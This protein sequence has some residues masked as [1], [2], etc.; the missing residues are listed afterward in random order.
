MSYKIRKTQ[1]SPTHFICEFINEPSSYFIKFSNSE[2]N[3]SELNELLKID[4]NTLE[5]NK[6]TDLPNE[7]LGT[8]L[9]KLLDQVINCVNQKPIELSRE[10]SSSIVKNP[11]L[12]SYRHLTA[13]QDYWKGYTPYALFK[14]LSEDL[15]EIPYVDNPAD[16]TERF[17]KKAYHTNHGST[18][19]IRQYIL[20]KNYLDF[21]K[22]EAKPEIKDIANQLSLEE[23]SCL[24]LA[25]FL[26]RSG[27][28]NEMGWVDD[29]TY[30]LRSAEIFSQIASDLGYN[31]KLIKLI[32]NSYDY[33]SKLLINESLTAQSLET[34]TKKAN[35]FRVL[36]KLAHETDLVRCEA[37]SE[38]LIEQIH[39]TLLEV[40]PEKTTSEASKAFLN[41][42]CVLCRETGA[43][44]TSPSHQLEK[45]DA[46]GNETKE[47]NSTHN[48]VA[49]CRRLNALKPKVFVPSSPTKRWYESAEHT[50]QEN[51][52]TK[53]WAHDLNGL[54]YFADLEWTN[55]Q[56]NTVPTAACVKNE[57][58]NNADFVTV[59]HATTKAS[60]A[61]E[62][63][64]KSLA[65]PGDEQITWHRISPTNKTVVTITDIE[66][67][68]ARSLTEVDNSRS[69][70][71]HLL[72]CNPTLWHN[73]DYDSQ[74]STVDYF[75]TD[76]SVTKL[77]FS[78]LI[79]ELLD[80][81]G[82]LIGQDQKRA[83]LVKAFNEL[84]NDK[85]FGSHGVI[86]QYHIPYHLVDEVAYIS[87]QNGKLD[88]ENPG[89]LDTLHSL[90]IS[91]VNIPNQ[92]TMQ[93]RL[94]VPKLMEIDVANQLKVNI[95]SGM[96]EVLEQEFTQI[97]TDLAIAAKAGPSLLPEKE[98]EVR[99][100]WR[101]FGAL[102]SFNS[103]SNFFPQVQTLPVFPS[104]SSRNTMKDDDY[105]P[106]FDEPFLMNLNEDED[107]DSSK[108][109][110][111]TFYG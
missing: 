28:T 110:R 71:W 80:Q 46:F 55:E 100:L 5:L 43:K 83:T 33:H 15:I 106:L 98:V 91:G 18:H 41:F 104:A 62:L 1:S 84:I 36:L 75:L 88:I 54:K 93:V 82:L 94:L 29:L 58:I 40:L 105:S 59:Y 2:F 103:R 70:Q 90:K 37:K 35:L 76:T 13:F 19:A 96:S 109:I 7:L 48:L 97:I 44:V 20:C 73:A 63:L 26:F 78:I 66:S 107:E 34:T 8:K 45:S 52:K 12:Y 56:V 64:C 3:I 24:E 38:P 22:R 102:N 68:K 50:Y 111:I 72:S 92:N 32:A 23:K 87:R 69:M 49:T 89:S 85:K 9:E 108:V 51:L 42:A 81:R 10:T 57:V 67:I 53:I 61:L 95:F 4:F 17:G 60:R 47:V 65:Q 16:I 77:D 101:G 30:G 21:F 14:I 27:R 11:V 99:G 79:I 74:E 6:I 86:Y 31:A 25:C 39:S